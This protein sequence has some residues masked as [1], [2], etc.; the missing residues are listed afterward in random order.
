M[1][2]F[3]WAV[4]WRWVVPV[5]RVASVSRD[6]SLPLEMHWGKMC[7]YD[8]RASPPRRDLFRDDSK[9]GSKL[10]HQNYLIT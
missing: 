5:D 1:N 2:G 8:K 7:L 3:L 10:S 9:D 4:I 6:L